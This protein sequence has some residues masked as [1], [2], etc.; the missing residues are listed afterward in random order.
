MRNHLHQHWA[1][2]GPLVE[3]EPSQHVQAKAAWVAQKAREAD[4]TPTEQQ[5]AELAIAHRKSARAIAQALGM[6]RNQAEVT[7]AKAL[8]ALSQLPDFWEAARQF[9][10]DL[11]PCVGNRSFHDERPPGLRGVTPDRSS[12]K[13]QGA[14]VVGFGDLRLRQGPLSAARLAAQ[15]AA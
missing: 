4:L 15:E 10:R 1:A 9:E 12:Q 2:T 13:F 6:K 8:N 5:V 3:T 14:D 11:L 7:Q